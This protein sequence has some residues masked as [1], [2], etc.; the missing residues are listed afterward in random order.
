MPAGFKN[1]RVLFNLCRAPDEGSSDTTGAGVVHRTNCALPP[2][3]RSSRSIR[4][5]T[6]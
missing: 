2:P 4:G 6:F 3:D 1:R 5:A